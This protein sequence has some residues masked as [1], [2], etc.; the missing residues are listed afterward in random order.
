MKLG[1]GTKLVTG[2]V[3]VAL[4]AGVVGITG[5]YQI[6]NIADADKTMYTKVTLGVQQLEILASSFLN[7]RIYVYVMQLSKNNDELKAAFNKF[8]EYK[9]QSTEAENN[10]EKTL[11]TKEGE[12]LLSNFRKTKAAYVDNITEVFKLFDS[13]DK[14]GAL[15]L[16]PK[17]RDTAAKHE[18]SLNAMLDNTIKFGEQVHKNNL[19]LSGFASITMMSIAVFGVIIALFIGILLTRSITKI[20][21]S[22]ESS[23][24]QVAIGAEQISASSEGLSQGVNEQAASVEEVSSSIEEMT[25]TIQ[26]NSDNASQTEKIAEKIATDAKDCG[27][28]VGKTVKAMQEIADKVSIIQEIARQTNLLSLNASIEAA[29]AGEHGKG[30]A[31]VASEVQKLAE[32]SQQSAVEIGQLS[33]TSVDIAIKAGELLN[34]LVPDIQKTADLVGEINAA[35]G[36]QASSITQINDAVQQLNSVVQQ[37]ASNSE[38]LAATAEELSAQT[39]NMKDAINYLKTGKRMDASKQ[40]HFVHKQPKQDLIGHNKKMIIGQLKNNSNQTLEYIQ[41]DAEN[42]KKKNGVKIEL[43]KHDNLDDAEFERY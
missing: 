12:T 41:E 25:S 38:E 9:D 29:R 22:V 37:N 43:K 18:A 13:N 14:E 6:R 36:E 15:L 19:N 33:K 1:I 5:M 26:Q 31:V 32:R 3:T 42:E 35:S 7:A 27:D 23:S 17:I 24:S 28:A 10:F 21:N 20:I 16:A 8:N 2:F 11:M 39:F 34:K 40:Q 30:F 4:I